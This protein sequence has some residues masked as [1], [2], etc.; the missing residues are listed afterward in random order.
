[1]ENQNKDAI[2]PPEEEGYWFR[3]HYSEEGDPPIKYKAMLWAISENRIFT[4]EKTEDKTF[5]IMERCDDYFS[6]EVTAS[7]LRDLGMELIAIADEAQK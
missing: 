5:V 1:M 4:V 6:I 2:A 3:S 7:Q